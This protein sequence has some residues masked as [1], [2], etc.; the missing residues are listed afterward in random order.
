VS[1]PKIL[2]VD[3]ERQ[4]RRFMR[5]GLEASD[6]R[7]VEAESGQEAL[8]LAAT[9]RPDL[10]ILDLG[11]PD[12]DGNEVIRRVRQ[13]SRLPIVVLSVRSEEDDKVA[14][15]DAGADDYLTK[16]FGMAELLA[17]IRVSL[18]H[19]GREEAAA[20]PKIS[21]GPLSM[22]AGERSA[23]ID[24]QKLQLTRK[25]F[26]LLHLL[27][28]HAGRVMTHRHLLT[29]IWGEAQAQD[30]AYLRVYVGQLRRKLGEAHHDLI[31]TEAGIGYRLSAE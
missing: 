8:R 12:M 30:T 26:D 2:M 7:V 9:E 14:A 29:S 4:I 19:A 16:P 1:A 11:L 27:A 22:D 6:Y 20:E 28:R 10:I 18:R 31:R 21:V 5:I 17:R 13:W 15:L 3:D 25:E 24:G 23:S